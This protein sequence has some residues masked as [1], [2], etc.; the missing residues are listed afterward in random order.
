V[1]T[2]R[3]AGGKRERG[4]EGGEAYCTTSTLLLVHVVVFGG[5]IPTKA[6]VVLP[7]AKFTAARA[8]L[9]G[10]SSCQH[11]RREALL[12]AEIAVMLRLVA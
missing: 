11:S 6:L 2:V 5:I 9:G 3:I 10:A 4:D 7:R 8:R 1:F 12:V